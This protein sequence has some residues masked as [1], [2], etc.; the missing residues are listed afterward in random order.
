MLLV[1]LC[2][3]GR[4]LTLRKVVVPLLACLLACAG[5]DPVLSALVMI[6]LSQTSS[7]HFSFQHGEN[8]IKVTVCSVCIYRKNINPFLFTAFKI[9]NEKRVYSYTHTHTAS[10]KEMWVLCHRFFKLFHYERKNNKQKMYW[11]CWVLYLFTFAVCVVNASFFILRFF[12]LYFYRST[13]VAK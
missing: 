1:Q 2:V 13:W 3:R 10:E 11:P 8:F 6:A 5:E 7:F 9:Q 4:G 12:F